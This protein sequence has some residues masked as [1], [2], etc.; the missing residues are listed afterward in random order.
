MGR[1]EGVVFPN[2]EATFVKE[3]YVL[4]IYI[5][6]YQNSLRFLLA[7]IVQMRDLKTSQQ[8]DI[9]IVKQ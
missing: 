5:L 9:Y 6:F 3:V 1:V 8:V 2:P 4:Y 7:S